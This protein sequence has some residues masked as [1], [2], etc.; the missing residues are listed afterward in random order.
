VSK[1]DEFGNVIWIN[2]K[3]LKEQFEHPGAKVYLTN[4]RILKIKAEEELKE[5]FRPMMDRRMTILETI[6]D[7]KQKIY[8]DINR[9]RVR[10]TFSN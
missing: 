4:K 2:M 7:L 8:S 3:T 5:N 10:E 6:I 1:K 9:I